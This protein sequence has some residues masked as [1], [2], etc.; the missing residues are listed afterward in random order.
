MRRERRDVFVS[1]LIYGGIAAILMIA[2][3]LCL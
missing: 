3:W 2:A 1:W